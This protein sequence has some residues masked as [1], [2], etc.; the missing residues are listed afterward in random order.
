VS[1]IAALA[2]PAA[3]AAKTA[4]KSI[5]IVFGIVRELTEAKAAVL[6]HTSISFQRSWAEALQENAPAR[7]RLLD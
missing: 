5:P 1:L 7:R 6:S 2:P 4:T 3:L